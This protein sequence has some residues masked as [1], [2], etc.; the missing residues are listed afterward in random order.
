MTELENHVRQTY[1]NKA[2]RAIMGVV[3]TCVLLLVP[4][5]LTVWW[6]M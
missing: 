1:R 5:G 3:D 2:R 4:I 6:W